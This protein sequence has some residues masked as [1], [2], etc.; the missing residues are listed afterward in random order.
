MVSRGIFAPNGTRIETPNSIARRTNYL[1]PAAA[2]LNRQFLREHAA[3][4]ASYSTPQIGGSNPAGL[5]F[6]FGDSW[7]RT[8]RG[9][10]EFSLPVGQVDNI[11]MALR[12]ACENVFV[13]KALR[14]KSM[15]M[16]TGLQQNSSDPVVTGFFEQ[17]HRQLFLEQIYRQ[18]VWLYNS[19][20]LVP[21]LLPEPGKPLEWLEILDPRMVRV[22]RAFGETFMYLVADRRM[23]NAVGDKNGVIDPRNKDYYNA[24][25]AYWRSQIEDR[26]NK[27]VTGEVLIK[28]KPGSYICIQNRYNPVDRSERGF[29]DTPLQ[30]YFA[31]CE[32]YRMLMSGD[33]AT[34]FLA[35]NLI[36]LVSVGDPEAEGDNYIRPDDNA[37]FGL[38]NVFQN[39]NKAQWVFGDPTINVRYIHPD[40][41]LLDSARYNE[42]KEQLK[43]LLP[44][45]FWFNDGGGSFAAA[46]VEM[47][48]LEQEV[49]ACHDAFDTQF[50]QPIYERAADGRKRIASKHV[51]PPKHDRN[52]LLD[53]AQHLESVNGLFNNGGLDI[54]TVMQEH[55]YDPDVIKQRL[56]DQLPDVKKG[57]YMPSFEQKQGIVA[58]KT[59]AITKQAA[60]PGKGQGGK[61]G[62]PKQSGSKPQ[63][64]ATHARTP[65]PSNKGK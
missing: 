6:S 33:F 10:M 4:N 27:G 29:D 61:G 11:N 24:M 45:P 56:Q 14:L 46:T 25:P 38:M 21:I 19:V 39:P 59:Y 13:A 16:T 64:E 26:R 36:A 1:I 9:V 8:Q 58:Q 2:T 17:V 5:G 32:Q 50:W 51:K 28:L 34:A 44:S 49:Q 52:A 22:E 63:S 57:I 62:R 42:P 41:A 12:F 35:K 3:N 47:K 37:V 30:P 7:L 20:G 18:A 54:Q 40:P 31:A 23:M 53:R 55:G 15:F 48:Q 43:N 60:S 65:R